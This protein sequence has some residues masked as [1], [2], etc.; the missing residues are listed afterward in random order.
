VPYPAGFVQV[1][2]EVNDCT[3]TPGAAVDAVL[4]Q[5]VPFEVRTLPEVP[6]AIACS[7][8]V[9][10]PRS[11]LLAASVEAPVPPL[12]TDKLPT[13]VLLAILIVLLV[14]VFVL[15]AVSR[16]VGVIIDVSVAI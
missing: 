8:D 13:N 12:A 3:F 15:S 11:T 1:P 2:E 6:G 4:A 9:P 5:V 14:K 10:L 16:L 7:A